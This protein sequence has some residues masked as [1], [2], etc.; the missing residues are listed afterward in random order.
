MELTLAELLLLHRLYRR[1]LNKHYMQCQNEVALL[2]R[3]E[4][5]IRA[6]GMGHLIIGNTREES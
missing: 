6:R 3:I 4:A 5:E 1:G 2:E